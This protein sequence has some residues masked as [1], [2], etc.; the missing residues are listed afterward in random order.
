MTKVFLSYRI[1][2]SAHVVR[3]ISRRM[4]ERLGR[5]NVF[6]DDDS[7]QLGMLYSND[8]RRA[9]E[10][11]DLVVAVIGHFW[12]EGTGDDGSRWLD[13]HQDWVRMELRTAFEQRIPVIPV[14]L[15]E[16]PL[17]PLDR[18]PADIRKL[19]HLQYWR[20]HRRTVD[21]DIE[22]LLDRLFPAGSSPADAEQPPQWP[23]ATQINRADNGSTIAANIGGTQHITITGDQ[24]GNS[25]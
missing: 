14:L 24:R 18:L 9:L 5:E 17:P 4:A 22:G 25:R 19:G 7:I 20:I 1:L 8:I 10:R 21:S 2:E 3:E 13:D 15:D 11:C 12:L 16:T 6:R 23:H